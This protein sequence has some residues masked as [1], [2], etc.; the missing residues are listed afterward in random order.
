MPIDNR[1]KTQLLQGVVSQ[2]L[3]DTFRYINLTGLDT[4]LV[5]LCGPMHLCVC[6][7]EEGGDG[8]G[9]D[10]EVSSLL[11]YTLR[12]VSLPELGHVCQFGFR[13]P[14]H[15]CAWMSEEGGDAS[16]VL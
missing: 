15:L 6:V 11:S 8:E 9:V 5:T 14:I 7:S 1:Q 13:E 2:S 3:S 12:Y 10:S 4:G 16:N